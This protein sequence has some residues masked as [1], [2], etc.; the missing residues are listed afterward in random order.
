MPAPSA[1]WKAVELR[2]CRALRLGRNPG[3]GSNGGLGS[4]GD[5]AVFEGRPRGWLYVE[6][7]HFAKSALFTLWKDTQKKA[8]LERRTPVV[9]MHEKGTQSYLVTLDLAFFRRILDIADRNG[10]LTEVKELADVASV[11]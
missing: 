11:D 3:S 9:I 6:I 10:T 5:C 2:V 4:C 7:K 1:T 8:I